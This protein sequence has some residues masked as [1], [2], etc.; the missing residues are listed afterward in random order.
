[1]VMLPKNYSISIYVFEQLSARLKSLEMTINANLRR[2]EYETANSFFLDSVFLVSLLLTTK[3]VGICT[4]Q[5]MTIT[6]LN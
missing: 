1:M 3:N 4:M 5:V 6:L 2:I